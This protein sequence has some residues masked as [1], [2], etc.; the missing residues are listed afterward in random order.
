M[1]SRIQH[2]RWLWLAAF[3]LAPA[4]FAETLR[5]TVWSLPPTSGNGGPTT[6]AIRVSQAAASLKALDP[7]VV[8]LQHVPDWQTCDQLVQALKPSNYGV[9]V[10]SA[11][12]DAGDGALTRRQAAIL[13]KRKAYFSWAEA[14]PSGQNPALGAAGFAFAAIRI[15][16]QSL[17]FYS[18]EMPAPST[19]RADSQWAIPAAKLLEH[20]QSVRNWENNRVEASVVGGALGDS[21]GAAA[22]FFQR[23]AEAG[24][25]EPLP[26]IAESLGGFLLTE[27][28][29][30][31]TLV[32]SD[33]ALDHS[34]VAFILDLAES[35]IVAARAVAYS[36]KAPVQAAISIVPASG[37]PAPSG[38][39]ML[40]R[41]RIGAIALTGVVLLLSVAWTCRLWIRRTPKTRRLLPENCVA[42]AY[43]FVVGTQSGTGQASPAMGHSPPPQP[44][45]HIEA[46]GT[47]HTHAQALQLR[48]TAPQQNA[49]PTAA[50]LRAGLVADLSRWL[51][52][53]L[54]RRLIT[55][56][57]R[58][59]DAQ[60]TAALKARA[61]E[62]RL[63]RIENQIQEQNQGYQRRIQELTEALVAARAENRELIL[64]QI[65]QV[66]AEMEAARAR[67]LTQAQNDDVTSA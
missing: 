12:R 24:F 61:V 32:N 51:K 40:D 13:S 36:A 22:G 67:L 30:W 7:D 56:R 17:G 34:P 63:A 19:S 45:I 35:R 16:N 33:A 23:L 25:G 20:V 50:A 43:T 14:W 29:G 53:R 8:L 46:A 5:V 59:L 44:V 57:S 41:W 52:Q 47:T 58:L 26:K 31:A 48:A 65:R 15:G 4:A 54:L 1:N 2:S 9:L 27:P 49:E 66:K 28:P 62:A 39:P 55:D 38:A 21:P 64:A 6:N 37:T 10:C 42:S 11:F 60:E 3:I 18:V